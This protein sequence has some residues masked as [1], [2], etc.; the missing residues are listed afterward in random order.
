MLSINSSNYIGNSQSSHVYQEEPVTDLPI[1]SS[2]K[3]LAND[4]DDDDDDD[5]YIISDNSRYR[6]NSGDIRKGSAY[7]SSLASPE[8]VNKTPLQDTVPKKAIA[9]SIDHYLNYKHILI[10]GMILLLV[11]C[12]YLYWLN[13]ACDIK[14]SDETNMTIQ[15]AIDKTIQMKQDEVFIGSQSFSDSKGYDSIVTV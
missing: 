14:E 5:D 12:T 3:D 7:P 8:V 4:D 13:T 10:F 1:H 9:W 2:L 11:S 15:Y 6:R